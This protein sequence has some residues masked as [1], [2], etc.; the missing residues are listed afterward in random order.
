MGDPD[1]LQCALKGALAEPPYEAIRHPYEI[2]N[3]TYPPIFEVEKFNNTL[4]FQFRAN[5]RNLN[6]FIGISKRK[7]IQKDSKPLQTHQNDI[8]PLRL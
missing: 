3:L 2:I 6:S 4:Y 7:I 8:N 1:L 5:V